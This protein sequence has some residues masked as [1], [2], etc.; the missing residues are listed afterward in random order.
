MRASSDS[1][2]IL[3]MYRRVLAALLAASAALP[4]QTA[5]AQETVDPAGGSRLDFFVVEGLASGDLLNIRA[6]ASATGMLIGRV[7]NGAKL[8]NLGCSD[9]NGYS[10][11]K[12]SDPQ[13]AQLTGWAPARYLVDFGSGPDSFQDEAAAAVEPASLG[14]EEFD[15]SGEIPCAREFGQPM[16]LCHADVRRRGRQEAD[17]VVTWPG[18]GE[19][20]IRF[21]AGK[22]EGSDAGEDIRA[23]REA[24]LHMIRIGKAERFEIPNALALGG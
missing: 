16:T 11:C 17:V 7:P 12:V 8:N 15:A 24:D 22:P 19:R 18:G 23:T 14:A 6:T 13:S 5:A 4:T 1:A 3:P 9:V 20:V 21:R 10:W 2:G